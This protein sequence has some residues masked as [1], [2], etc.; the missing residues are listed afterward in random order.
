MIDAGAPIDLVFSDVVMPGQDGL[1]LARQVE[2]RRPSLPVVL[3]T[4]RPDVV[5]SVIERGGVALLKP[6]TIERLEAVFSEQLAHAARAIAALALCGEK[7]P[8]EHE[9]EGP[10]NS[11]HC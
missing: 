4:G 8:A 5:D 1:T 11:E 6:Y 10:G 9:P 3:A 2:T 7:H